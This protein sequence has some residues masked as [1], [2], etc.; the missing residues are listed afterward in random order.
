MAKILVLVCVMAAACGGDDDG[1]IGPGMQ[2]YEPPAEQQGSGK[3]G[4]ATSYTCSQASDCGYWFCRCEDGAVVNSA[5]CVNGFCMNAESACPRA[6][7]YFNHGAWTGEAGGGPGGTTTPPACGGLGSD[8]AACD[9]CMKSQCCDEAS[10]CG[11]SQSCFNY[12][13]C[14]VECDG[15]P[16]CR[17]ECEDS[18]PSGVGPYEG[19]SSCLLDNCYMQCVGDL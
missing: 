11:S 6:C 15:D 10:A 16:S 9:S 17:A 13:D 12:W 8:L 14:V 5:L 2:D 18:Y 3:P 1:S 7:E 19:L 4:G